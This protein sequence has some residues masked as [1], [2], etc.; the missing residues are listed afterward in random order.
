MAH[1]SISSNEILTADTQ[2]NNSWM[3]PI[4]YYMKHGILPN[5][6]KA[7]VETKARETR[8]ALLNEI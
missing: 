4:A 2:D 5:D 7:I 6:K 3:S 1:Y 8:Y